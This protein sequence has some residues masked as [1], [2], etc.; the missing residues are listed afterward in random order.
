M[1]QKRHCNL[2]GTAQVIPKLSQRN[3][4]ALFYHFKKRLPGLPVIFLWHAVLRVQTDQGLLF[5]RE[6]N[7]AENFF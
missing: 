6:V 4:R 3:R 7:T 2:A 1:L 5:R